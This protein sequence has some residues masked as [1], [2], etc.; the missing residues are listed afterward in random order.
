MLEDPESHTRQ[1]NGNIACYKHV[2]SSQIHFKL[3]DDRDLSPRD[4]LR[5]KKKLFLK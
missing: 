1:P 2:S 4:V 3:W 5:K